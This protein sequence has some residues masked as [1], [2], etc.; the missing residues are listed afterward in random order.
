LAKRP[1]VTL[2]VGRYA[3]AGGVVLFAI[4]FALTLVQRLLFGRAEIGC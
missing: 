4:I 2:S 3:A 1:A